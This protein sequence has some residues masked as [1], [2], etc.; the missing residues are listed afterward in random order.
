MLRGSRPR[1]LTGREVN[2]AWR[3]ALGPLLRPA[4]LVSLAAHLQVT[5]RAVQRWVTAAG[6][7]R[8][9]IP[10][11]YADSTEWALQGIYRDRGDVVEQIGKR[12]ELNACPNPAEEQCFTELFSSVADA[13]DW[14][15][16]LV[17]GN[18]DEWLS[19]TAV[20]ATLTLGPQGWQVEVCY[21]RSL[22]VSLAEQQAPE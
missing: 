2:R 6:Q 11:R 21:C 5:V 10:A 14:E 15:I 16:A 9:P 4:D 17:D 22:Y 3:E 19:T 20:S 13:L 18:L 1:T 12:I 8:N 7:Q